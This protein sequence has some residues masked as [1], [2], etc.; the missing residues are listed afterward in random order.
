MEKKP[1]RCRDGNVV[2]IEGICALRCGEEKRIEVCEFN[3]IESR[4]NFY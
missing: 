3:R 1:G 4:C 2:K